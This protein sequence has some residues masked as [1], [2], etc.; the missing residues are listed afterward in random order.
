MTADT[1][2]LDE[3]R[4]E[5]DEID[6]AVHDLLMRRVALAIYSGYREGPY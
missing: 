2:S 3:L 6:V 4:R 5:I 1:P